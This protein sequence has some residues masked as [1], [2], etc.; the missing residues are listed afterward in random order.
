MNGNM[1]TLHL[2]AS[3]AVTHGRHH[4]ACLSRFFAIAHNSRIHILAAGAMTLFTLHTVFSKKSLVF[5]PLLHMSTGCVAAEA[6][7]RF[8][9]LLWYTA[10]S[11]DF[12]F[13]RL[14]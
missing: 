7:C 14:R 6:H 3:H 4:Q 10:Q 2:V 1:G 11:G 13:F 9:R 8:L 5:F 12:F